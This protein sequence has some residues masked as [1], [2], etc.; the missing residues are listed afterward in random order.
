MR[1]SDWSSDVCSSDLDDADRAGPSIDTQEARTLAARDCPR[2]GDREAPL[3][4]RPRARDQRTAIVPPADAVS[5]VA[6][7]HLRNDAKVAQHAV[8][9]GEAEIG[10]AHV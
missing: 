4:G 8:L 5:V 2:I 3:P 10:R 6:Q 1:I 9:D 7:R